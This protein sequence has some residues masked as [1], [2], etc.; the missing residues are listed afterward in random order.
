MHDELPEVE[1]EGSLYISEEEWIADTA[2]ECMLS[3]Y[4]EKGETEHM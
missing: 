4:W 3:E 2:E 1:K